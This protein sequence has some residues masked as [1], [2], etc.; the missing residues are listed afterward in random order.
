MKFST[1]IRCLHCSH[2]ELDSWAEPKELESLRR[3]YVKCR[4]CGRLYRLSMSMVQV[5]P[6]RVRTA[7]T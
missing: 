4:R 6:E 5:N 2:D 3:C 1:A 7:R